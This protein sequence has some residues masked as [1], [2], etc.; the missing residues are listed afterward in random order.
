V[1]TGI[2]L[3]LR[4]VA[5]ASLTWLGACNSPRGPDDDNVY[6]FVPSVQ[7]SNPN[8][9]NVKAFCEQRIAEYKAIYAKNGEASAELLGDIIECKEAGRAI[10]VGSEEDPITGERKLT[11]KSMTYEEASRHQESR[12]VPWTSGGDH[13]SWEAPAEATPELIAKIPP[14][15]QDKWVTIGKGVKLGPNG[16][17][18]FSAAVCNR[19]LGITPY[20]NSNTISQDEWEELRSRLG[21]KYLNGSTPLLF[22][23]RYYGTYGYCTEYKTVHG[24]CAEYAEMK[25]KLADGCDVK[26]YFAQHISSWFSSFSTLTSIG[27]MH[28]ETVVDASADEK[29]PGACFATTNSWGH[30]ATVSGGTDGD[31]IHSR[32]KSSFKSAWPPNC[33]TLWVD[34]TCKCDS[35]WPTLRYLGDL[36]KNIL[37]LK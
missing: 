13:D 16:C 30:H 28:I 8:V 27:G 9:K 21:S 18:V 14:S 29:T 19:K 26:F 24:T 2:S 12:G 32:N 17:G 25:Q 15:L 11:A 3:F 1:Q 20:V 36:V 35:S 4:G 6:F 31:F 37:G 23:A 10:V 34:Y 22:A 5:L 7:D 33:S